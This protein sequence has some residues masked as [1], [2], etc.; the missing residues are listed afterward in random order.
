MH[1]LPDRECRLATSAKDSSHGSA[2]MA[3]EGFLISSTVPTSVGSGCGN[4]RL[5]P[6]RS[7]SRAAQAIGPLN[8]PGQSISGGWMK[9]FTG[10]QPSRWRTLTRGECPM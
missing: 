10:L 8:Q 3:A 9:I 7:I 6:R 5:K 2:E 1:F 4:H